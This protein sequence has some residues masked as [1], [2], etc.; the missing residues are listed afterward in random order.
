MTERIPPEQ[1]AQIVAEV[2]LLARSREAEFDKE[3]I[4]Q[5]L[6]ELNLP[7]DLLEEALVQ[8]RRRE[9]LAVEQKRNRWIALGLVVVLTSA[10]ATTTILRQ[11]RQ[12]ALA[13]IWASQDR[14][15]LAQNPLSQLKVVESSLRP[16]VYYRVTLQEVPLGRKVSLK[17]NWIDPSGQIVHQN[18]YQT[19]KIN[20][21]IWST[22]CRYQFGSTVATGTWQ[23]QMSLGDRVLSSTSLRV[24]Q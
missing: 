3:Q 8:L 15:T 5:I 20:Q 7:P 6:L 14:I 4:K 23:V 13:R 21:E 22:Y 10:I 11:N 2:E 19:R 12:Q 17:C 9:A 24:K 16:E 18:S 1:L